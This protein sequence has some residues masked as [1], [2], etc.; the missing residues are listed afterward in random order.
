M[1]RNILILLNF[2][3]INLTNLFAQFTSI[4]I[5]LVTA[6]GDPLTGQAG[7]IE[8]TKYPHNYPADKIT[9]LSVSE[10]GTAGN[11]VAKGFNAFQY[12]KLWLS[13][14]NQQWFDSVLTGN[15]FNYLSS[16]Y[17]TLGTSQTI[18][19]Q[20]TTTGNW[21][22]T[23]TG[24]WIYT[25]TSTTHTFND[26]YISSSSSKYPYNPSLQNLIWR[27][28]A[29]SF[30]FPREWGYYSSADNKLYFSTSGSLGTFRI[31]K[32]GN[33]QL[34]DFN[35]TQFSWQSATGL[36]LNTDILNRDSIASKNYTG[37]KDS[38]WFV[39]GEPVSKYRFLT[40]KKPFWHNT[41]P[42]PDW[43]W[44]YRSVDENNTTL[45]YDSF[46]VMNH[47]DMTIDAVPSEVFGDDAW[48]NV[49]TVLL[50][51]RGLYTITYDCSVIFP[52]SEVSGVTARDSVMLRFTDQ[53]N[54]PKEG[55]Y[56][57]IW[58]DFNTFFAYYPESRPVSKTFTFFNTVPNTPYFLQVRADLNTSLVNAAVTRPQITY[59]LIR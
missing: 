50:P 59:V 2:S 3:F 47:A 31:A 1:K 38:T 13:G 56:T 34:F 44:F 9:G 37:I 53:L 45:A 6:S 10:I 40:L 19:G 52:Y 27:S 24:N 55:S 23:T 30:Y 29:D 21:L 16:N 49:D 8:F 35:N 32:R 11:Y 43:K 54:D 17:V 58:K 5:R 39:L 20:K 26:P 46:T 4:P 28:Y 36:N 12:A 51:A 25:G 48:N 7:N 41:L 15:I 57:E 22:G 33:T 18:T 14:V 42:Y